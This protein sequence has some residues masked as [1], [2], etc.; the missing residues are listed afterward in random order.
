MTNPSNPT[1]QPTPEDKDKRDPVTILAELLTEAGA[2]PVINGVRIEHPCR[3]AALQIWARFVG[4]PITEPYTDEFEWLENRLLD[5]KD[6]IAGTTTKRSL[7]EVC[8]EL[9]R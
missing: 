4:I 5:L 9:K 2:V 7:T 6:E 8:Q 1:P 3:R